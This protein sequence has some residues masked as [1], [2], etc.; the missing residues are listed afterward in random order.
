MT[1]TYHSEEFATIQSIVRIEFKSNQIVIE[2]QIDGNN[3]DDDDSSIFLYFNTR[4]TRNLCQYYK[5]DS[6]EDLIDHIHQHFTTYNSLRRY[7]DFLEKRDI[8]S[9][10]SSSCAL[11]D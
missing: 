11:T 4:E 1:K 9:T 8:H 7:Q 5:T 10:I 6:N 3:F 2:H